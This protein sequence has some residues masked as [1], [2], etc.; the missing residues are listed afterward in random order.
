MNYRP[1]AIFARFTYDLVR[2]LAVLMILVAMAAAAAL[3]YARATGHM[4][5][6][7]QSG[8]MSP[9]LRPGDA[10]L[11]DRNPDSRLMVGDIVTFKTPEYPGVD[12]THRLVHIDTN[13]DTLVTRGDAAAQD[14]KRIARDQVIG[15]TQRI[16]PG[17]G[18]G[19]D[20][21]RRPIGLAA[22]LYG[23]VLLLAAGELRRLARHYDSRYYRLHSYFSQ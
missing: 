7:I 14:D 2:T 13:G 18:Y 11:V 4:I 8:S 21:L 3:V 5:Y 20:F 10:I 17:V 23:P 9:V 19:F 1:T 6:T 16:V 15:A 22:A 12:V